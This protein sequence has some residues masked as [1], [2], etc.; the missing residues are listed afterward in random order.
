VIKYSK[1][2]I[3]EGFMSYPPVRLSKNTQS[4]TLDCSN[5]D[6]QGLSHWF[7]TLTEEL[8]KKKRVLPKL[9]LSHINL[10]HLEAVIR[11]IPLAEIKALRLMR[12]DTISDEWRS[13]LS[14]LNQGIDFKL[15]LERNSAF[16]ELKSLI[17][18]LNL[19]FFIKVSHCAKKPEQR[20]LD[21]LVLENRTQNQALSNPNLAIIH[22]IKKQKRTRPRL[23][24]AFLPALSV[25]VEQQ[26]NHEVM[27]TVEEQVQQ[28]EA[29]L[30][31][32]TECISYRQFITLFNQHTNT[33]SQASDASQLWY[34]V[35]AAVAKKTADSDCL[36]VTESKLEAD[37]SLYSPTE[38]A[39]DYLRHHFWLT[40]EAAIVIIRHANQFQ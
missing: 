26:M 6:V 40:T 35:M 25:D 23:Q 8:A 28:E 20:E 13:L 21:E 10:K 37:N 31:Q 2:F 24:A 30:E 22:P 39:V 11:L 15:I 4:L 9:I 36:D 7:S 19:C 12:L 38:L 3:F 16:S 18:D 14:A 17:K 33:V 34:R 32:K 29:L 27:N 1:V 5:L